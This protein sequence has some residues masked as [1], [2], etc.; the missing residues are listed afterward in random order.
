MKKQNSINTLKTRYNPDFRQGLSIEEVAKQ[1]ENGAQ[2]ITKDETSKSYGKIIIGNL[3][4]FF[5]MLMF[6]IAALFFIAKGLAAVTNVFF[7]IKNFI[8]ICY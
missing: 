7:L 1:K 6:G 3:F 4:T 8:I 2:N 5:N